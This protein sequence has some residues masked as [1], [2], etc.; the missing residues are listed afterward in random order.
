VATEQGLVPELAAAALRWREAPPAPDDAQ[1][2]QLVAAGL[3]PLY[4][5]L[6]ADHE[7]RMHEYGELALAE[8]FAQWRIQLTTPA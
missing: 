1:A 5:L 4:L 8:Q 3:R 7:H 6:I 2:E